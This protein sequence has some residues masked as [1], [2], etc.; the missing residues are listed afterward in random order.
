MRIPIDDNTIGYIS[1]EPFTQ[2]ILRYKF[3]KFH[4]HSVCSRDKVQITFGE[5]KAKFN[6]THTSTIESDPNWIDNSELRE[7]AKTFVFKIPNK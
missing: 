3:N 7:L 6:T 2:G 4:E 1:S 5:F